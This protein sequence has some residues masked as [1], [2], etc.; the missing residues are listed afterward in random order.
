MP[1]NLH[2]LWHE[3]GPFG[4]TLRVITL[5][6]AMILSFSG[7][8]DALPP[9]LSAHSPR[10]LSSQVYMADETVPPGGTVQLKFFLAQPALIASGE[11]TMDLDPTMFSSATGVSTFSANG[12]AA[13]VAH[14]EGLHVDIL[15]TSNNG[16]IGRLSSVPIVVVNATVLPTVIAGQTASVT[17]NNALPWVGP[18]VPNGS[19][20]L[21][22]PTPFSVTVDPGTVT[23]GGTL[24]ISNIAPV[25]GVLPS[26]TAITIEGTGFT[27]GTTAEID[28]AAVASVQVVGP[29]MMSVILAGPTELIGKRVRVIHPDGSEI[30]AFPFVPEP[31]VS[32]PGT[33]ADGVIPVLP[34]QT[35]TGF[36]ADGVVIRNPNVSAVQLLLDYYFAL[37]GPY[38]EQ[39]ITLDAG[40][41]LFEPFTFDGNHV[42]AYSSAPVQV[43]QFAQSSMLLAGPSVPLPA[44]V[45]GTSAATQ[46]QSNSLNWTWQIGA[47]APQAQTIQVYL[48]ENQRTTNYTTSFAT[49]SGGPWLSVTPATTIQCSTSN[50]PCGTLQVSVNPGSLAPGTYRGSVTITPVASLFFPLVEPEVIPVSLTITASAPALTQ[51][52]NGFFREGDLPLTVALPPGMFTGPAALTVVTDSGGN[53]LSAAMNNTSPIG[54]NSPTSLTIAV[55]A[56]GFAVGSYSGEI[57]IT[58]SGNTFVYTAILIVDGAVRLLADGPGG[59]LGT[60]NIPVQAGAG[61]PPPQVVSIS[62]EDCVQ[63]QCFNVNPDLSSLAASVQ[64]HSGGNWLSAA[65]SQGSVVVSANPAGLGV[66]VYLGAVTFTANAVAPTQFPVVLIV[67]GGSP[68]ALI[69][70]PGLITAF[71]PL[72]GGVASQTPVPAQVCIISA[73]APTTFTVQATTSDGSGWLS[74][75]STGGTTN[76]NADPTCVSYAINNSASLAGGVYNGSIVITAASQTLT[77]PVTLTVA[78]SPSVPFLGAVASESSDIPGALFPGETVAIQGLNLAPATAAVATTPTTTLGGVEVLIAGIPASILY[79]TPTLITAVVPSEVAGPSN[80]TVQVQNS[81]GSTSAWAIPLAQHFPLPRRFN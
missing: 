70:G 20:Q 2:R 35:V 71:A 42:T 6:I 43:V 26:G 47:A 67:E 28:G 19:G 11:L 32:A 76:L 50:S 22:S 40:S 59:T 68:P 52:S 37:G 65:V 9:P 63:S 24:S 41:S 3:P 33:L 30:D 79:A 64:T 44:V 16:G 8:A 66:G 25:G 60:L 49:S 31:P 81:S 21:T 53:W 7:G 74:V 38:N 72:G 18:P 73:F 34:L 14:I 69:A 15:F 62:T 48:P 36:Y 54:M 51:V 78:P 55:N 29:Q 4:Y 13:G 45:L 57:T 17:A 46:D 39:T 58:G 56:A 23:I 61:P 27:G 12:D 77:I 75:A 80:V 10:P 5:Q 1:H